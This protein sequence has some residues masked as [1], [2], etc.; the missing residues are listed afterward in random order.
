LKGGVAGY[1]VPG[2][3]RPFDFGC[4]RDYALIR[5]FCF[6]LTA[7][8]GEAAMENP[9]ERESERFERRRFL[10]IAGLASLA[11]LL[12][13]ATAWGRS[14]R[15][16]AKERSLSLPPEVCT[17]TVYGTKSETFTIFL[18]ARTVTL[19]ETVDP[20]QTGTGTFTGVHIS[21]DTYTVPGSGGP[22][23]V[24]YTVS[25]STSHS[26]SYT[27]SFTVSASTVT[28]SATFPD[29]TLT[30]T[31][32]LEWSYTITQECPHMALPE[33]MS[34]ELIIHDNTPQD[35]GDAAAKAIRINLPTKI[36]SAL[37]RGWA[38]HLELGLR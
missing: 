15:L 1:R 12:T 28:V 8:P 21:V 5:G 36:S 25:G 29:Q 11:G 13:P 33:G 4:W 9:S 37:S 3:L 34:R 30:A 20:P 31:D 27:A 18:P 14:L 16:P 10:G 19:T 22:P 38:R 32:T 2:V 7:T 17:V 23:P 26:F 24:T 6:V 35:T